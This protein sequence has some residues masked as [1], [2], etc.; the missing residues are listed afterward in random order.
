MNVAKF[1]KK[2]RNL[3]AN[4]ILRLQ[5]YDSIKNVALPPYNALP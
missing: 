4:V 3:F 2:Q 5:G 1:I